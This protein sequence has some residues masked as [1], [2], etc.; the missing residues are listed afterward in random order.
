[1]CVWFFESRLHLLAAS[2]P[3]LD[4]VRNE[5][6][7][8]VQTVAFSLAVPELLERLP[9]GRLCEL[10]EAFG[11]CRETQRQARSHLRACFKVFLSWHFNISSYSAS[12]LGMSKPLMSFQIIVLPL[13]RLKMTFGPCNVCVHG[14]EKKS[15]DC[16][17]LPCAAGSGCLQKA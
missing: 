10:V 1:M 2:D 13:I 14:P 5:V 11:R 7:S 12:E 8:L 4:V 17:F 9:L 6:T 3:Q 15:T 16:F